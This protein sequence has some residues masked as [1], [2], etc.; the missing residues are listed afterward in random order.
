MS[1]PF[2]ILGM[3]RSGT[4]VVTKLLELMGAYVGTRDELLP[5]SPDNPKGFF[6]RND[7]LAVNQAIFRHHHSNWYTVGAYDTPCDPLPN[8]ITDE[9]QRIVALMSAHPAW[10]IKDPRLCFTLPDWLTY[11]PNPIIITVSRNPAEIAQSLML[12]NNIPLEDGYALWQSYIE[13]ALQHIAGKDVIKCD[14]ATLIEQGVETTRQLFEQLHARA[15]QLRAPKPSDVVE[16]ISPALR[17]SVHRSDLT[18]TQQALFNR[19][20]T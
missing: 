2:I 16:F 12:R 19:W 13:H 7:V 11:I 17:R 9:M 20:Q 8:T 14:Y 18:E 15:P 1:Q 3:H 5:P 4:S 6:E 10:V